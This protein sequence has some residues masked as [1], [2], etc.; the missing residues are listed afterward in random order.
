MVSTGSP[1][2][3]IIL[4][5]GADAEMMSLLGKDDVRIIADA[6]GIARGLNGPLS[7]AE[8]FVII[9]LSKRKYRHQR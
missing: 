7:S 2:N 3:A 9:D 1:E 5:G 4:R 8:L 6:P